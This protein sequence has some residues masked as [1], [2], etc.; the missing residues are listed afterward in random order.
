MHSFFYKKKNCFYSFLF[1]FKIKNRP[2]DY[3]T[4]YYRQVPQIC[5]LPRFKHLLLSPEGNMQISLP[6]G[7]T[8]TTKITS[9]QIYVHEA[10][11]EKGTPCRQLVGLAH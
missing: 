9:V 10:L 11:C 8:T 1:F 2:F 7:R 3:C 6:Q 5:F 4:V